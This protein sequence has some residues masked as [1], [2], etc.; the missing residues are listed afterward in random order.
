[1]HRRTQP[2]ERPG[3]HQNGR[4]P[5]W[6][7]CWLPSKRV[8]QQT[9]LRGTCLPRR[10][11]GTVHGRT[12][13]Q[14]MF[15]QKQRLLKKEKRHARCK[16]LAVGLTNHPSLVREKQGLL[17]RQCDVAR[18]LAGLP[19]FALVPVKVTILQPDPI[20]INGDYLCNAA[21]SKRVAPARN[22]CN[23]W[24]L[25]PTCCAQCQPSGETNSQNHFDSW[26]AAWRQV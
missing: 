8:A 25:P 22:N 15:S 20:P 12:S 17:W 6:F 14:V 10:R 4:G 16:Y 3:A 26:H 9:Y 21:F 11:F 1:M 2:P 24:Q 19:Y 5:F 13:Q 7:W 18:I 23:G